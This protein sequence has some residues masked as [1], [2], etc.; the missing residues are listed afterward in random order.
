MMGTGLP[1]MRACSLIKILTI[2]QP[3]RP[4]LLHKNEQGGHPYLV[5]CSLNRACSRNRETRVKVLDMK[6]NAVQCDP[7]RLTLRLWRSLHF[8]DTASKIVLLGVA[9]LCMYEKT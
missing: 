8:A 1:I 4:F 2:F 3:A 6:K 5:P 7:C 9:A